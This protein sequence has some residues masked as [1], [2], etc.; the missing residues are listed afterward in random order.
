[1]ENNEEPTQSRR[2]EYRAESFE[3]EYL[4]L[5]SSRFIKDGQFQPDPAFEYFQVQRERKISMQNLQDTADF[6]TGKCSQQQLIMKK[7]E[8]KIGLLMLEIKGTKE[9][10]CELEKQSLVMEDK[11]KQLQEE[12]EYIRCTFADIVKNLSSCQKVFS[13]ANNVLEDSIGKVEKIA[14]TR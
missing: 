1:M 9:R 13:S 6:Y 7:L 8:N 10:C 12:K 4:N 5:D 11:I 14:N 2:I 3:I